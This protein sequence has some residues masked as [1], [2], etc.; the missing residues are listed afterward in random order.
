L[1]NAYLRTGRYPRALIEARARLALRPGDRDAE[2]D[3][4][5]LRAFPK[6]QRIAKRNASRVNYRLGEGIPVEINGNHGEFG[7][8]TGAVMSFISESEA[9]RMGLRIQDSRARIGNIA[10]STAGLKTAVADRLKIGSFEVKQVAFMVFR[11]DQPPFTKMPIGHRGIIGIPVL[12]ALRT[13]SMHDGILEF[14]SRRAEDAMAQANVAFD[15][16]TPVV[17]VNVLGRDLIF[18]F[19]TGAQQTFLYQPFVDAFP[20][21][22][23]Q[24]KTGESKRVTGIGQSLQIESATLPQLTIGVGAF[25]ASLGP[26]RV[27]LKNTAHGSNWFVGNLGMDFLMQAHEVTLDFGTRKLVLK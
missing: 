26:V 25:R 7:F 22:L 24:T 2:G 14:G 10:G 8:D 3:I 18:V 19:D 13:I 11:D 20:G 23:Q 12:L 15:D 27:L 6:E 9:A 1:E 16:S 17:R 21:L 4:A 5:L